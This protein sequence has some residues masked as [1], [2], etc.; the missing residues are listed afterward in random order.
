MYFL[1]NVFV[2]LLT[3]LPLRMLYYV[4]DL[5]YF[6]IFYIVR[7]RKKIVRKNLIETFPQKNITEIKVIEKKFYRYF[8][9]LILETLK[10]INITD[11]ELNHIFSFKN[12]ELIIDNYNDGRSIFVMSS[13]YC[14]WEVCASLNLQLPA[15]KP[16]YNVYKKLKNNKF[17][18]F[19]LKL[20]SRYGGINLEKDMLIRTLIELKSSNKQFSVGMIS[21]QSPRRSSNR[22]QLNFLGRKTWFFTGTEMLARK[23]SMP[24]YYAKIN[25][26]KRGSYV[27]EIV[28]V[29]TD[30]QNSFDGE[31]TQKFASILEEQI[32][33]NPEFW[34]WTHKRWKN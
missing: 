23:Y 1:F 32:L 16:L 11:K 19:M 13:H 29:C 31:I 28:P 7:Y 22:T 24:V 25:R 2:R 3:L 6:I 17:D 10:Q 15:E 9:D 14:N 4:S 8:C 30:I 27:C 26:I 5:L 21:D 12:V 20:R 34:L 18:A 33:E